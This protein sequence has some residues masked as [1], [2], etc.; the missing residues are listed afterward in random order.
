MLVH[1][2]GNVADKEGDAMSCSVCGGHTFSGEC[3][4]CSEII[5]V[6]PCPECG[7]TGI[8]HRLAFNIRTRQFV[9][10]TALTWEILP[11]DEDRAEAM[12]WNYCRAM[13]NCPHCEG[14]GEVQK[15]VD[16]TFQALR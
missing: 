16:G 4:A 10:V 6:V 14:I 12:G 11:S 13:E 15:Y 5:G 9:E 8:D 3:P 2:L 1:H 7:G